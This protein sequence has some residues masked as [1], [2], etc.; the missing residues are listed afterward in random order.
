M[1]QAAPKL[2][3]YLPAIYQDDPFLNQFLMAF[4]EILLGRASDT[5][6]P[7]QGLERTIAQIH[8]LFDP[9]KTPKEFLPWLAEWTA[10][11]IRADLAPVQQQAFIAKVISLYRR[12]GTVG[13]LKDLLKIFVGVE[14][15]IRDTSLPGGAPHY[16]EVEIS[17]PGGLDPTKRARQIEIAR[18]LID[19]EKPSHT[20]YKLI[21]NFL[22][23]IQ[24]GNPAQS[25]LGVNTIL[26]TP[27]P[28][29]NPT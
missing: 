18:A 9:I 24:I 6:F 12:R 27:P 5:D 17:W 10:F 21:P 1:T 25:T 3:D 11:T 28:P 19:I 29:T 22:S 23:T 2:Q 26:G 7:S 4:E 8:Q 14:P 13:N 20:Y 15:I 16:F